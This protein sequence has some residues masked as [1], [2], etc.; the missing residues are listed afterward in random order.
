MDSDEIAAS[1]TLTNRKNRLEWYEREIEK[2]G[3]AFADIL[4]ELR[5]DKL[6]PYLATHNSLSEY[7]QD[8]WNMTQRR[9][10]QLMAAQ[11][12]RDQLAIEDPEIAPVVERMKEGPIREI[13]A[14][15]KEKRLAILRAAIEQPGTKITAKTIKQAK[16]RI[17][18]T[19]PNLAISDAPAPPA[20]DPRA[21]LKEAYLLGFYSSGE[22]HNGEY[23]Q[24]DPEK[25]ER[26]CAQRDLDLKDLQP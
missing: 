25:S 16:A 6:K 3:K 12:V 17:I 10:Q 7:L 26:W 13:A 21:A 23:H 5:D 18:S 8:R 24:G 22:G 9:Q 15:P 2:R 20:P 14:A 1:L 4:R 11:S 19:Q